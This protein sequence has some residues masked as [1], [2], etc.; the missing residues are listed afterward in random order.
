MFEY[1][2]SHYGVN[3]CV[4]RRVVV[5]GQPGIITGVNNAHIAVNFDDCKPCVV[6][7][8]HPTWRV[9]YQ[10]MSEVRKLT[11][12]QQRYRD[13][14]KSESCESFAEW[15]GVDRASRARRQQSKKMIGG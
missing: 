5:D 9:E 11:A 3:A 1:I 13:Y 12:G 14:L 4:G 15:L 7:Y 8:C 2:N 6:A 10:G